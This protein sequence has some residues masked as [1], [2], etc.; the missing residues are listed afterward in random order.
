MMPAVW[1]CPKKSKTAEHKVH[2]LIVSR[3][4][5][6]LN[7]RGKACASTISDEYDE[8]WSRTQQTLLEMM[9]TRENLWR[10]QTRKEK[11]GNLLCSMANP[12]LWNVQFQHFDIS[13][14]TSHCQ[15]DISSPEQLSHICTARE[16]IP[17]ETFGQNWVQVKHKCSHI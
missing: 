11:K 16:W 17:L 8:K 13:S 1:F 15:T 9:T 10:Q 2:H 3:S 5:R 4:V 14:R 12:I 6:S 7:K